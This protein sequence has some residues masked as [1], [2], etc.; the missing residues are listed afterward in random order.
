[1]TARF[2]DPG[3]L[4]QSAASGQLGALPIVTVADQNA[5]GAILPGSFVEVEIQ[6]RVR[7]LVEVPAEALVVRGSKRFA[8]V[9]DSDRHLR[10]RP[11]RLADDDGQTVRVLD[12][13]KAGEIVALNVGETVDDGALVEPVLRQAT[14]SAASR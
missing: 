8:A 1:V 9:V 14:P 13:V 12:G 3:A 2:A 6:I 11:V 7:S 5:D 10:L 4:I